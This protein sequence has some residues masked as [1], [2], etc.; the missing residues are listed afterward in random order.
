MKQLIILISIGLILCSQS[1]SQVKTVGE[2]IQG[3]FDG[4][5][6]IEYVIAVK[7]KEGIGNPIDDDNA[8]PTEYEI[9]FSGNK[10]KPIPV[11]CCDLRLI[12]EGDLNNNATDEISIFQAPMNGCTYLMATYSF[13]NGDWKQ[14]IKPFLIPTGCDYMSNEDLQKRIF[15]ENNSVY[16]YDTNFNNGKL[17]RKKVNFKVN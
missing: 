17:I 12:N 14:I 9:Q 13:I 10:L 8:I 5:G 7:V 16:Y 6:K 11:G 15:K 3:D 2:K 1:F 4:D